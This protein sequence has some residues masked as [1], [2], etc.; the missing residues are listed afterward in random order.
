MNGVSRPLIEKFYAKKNMA[1][2]TF[3]TQIVGE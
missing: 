1:K 3:M 2:V